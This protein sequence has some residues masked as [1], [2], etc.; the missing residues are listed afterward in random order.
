MLITIAMIII[1][2]FSCTG[3]GV[4]LD[5]YGNPTGSSSDSLIWNDNHTDSTSLTA[6]L[7]SIQTNIFDAFCAVKCHKSPRPKK[8]L[9][10]ED[11]EAYNHLVNIESKEKPS[12]MRVKPFN[13]ENSY[14]IWKLEGR[15]GISGKQMPLNQ[16]PLE[17]TQIEAIRDWIDLGA[18]E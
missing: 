2:L 9:N 14:I 4:G 8:G 7:E 16:P 11:G 10:L 15:T 17:D 5:E 6:T 3:D 12:M 13:S 1:F 18:P